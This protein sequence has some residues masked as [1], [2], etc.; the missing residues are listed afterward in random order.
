MVAVVVAGIVD[1][2][3]PAMGELAPFATVPMIV[4]LVGAVPELT[5][6]TEKELNSTDA[7]DAAQP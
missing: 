7:P 1:T 2:C 4:E 6:A 5:A 3:T